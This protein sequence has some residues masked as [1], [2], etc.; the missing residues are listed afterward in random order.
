MCVGGGGVEWVRAGGLRG[1][2]VVTCIAT[3]SH[4]DAF[5]VRV[6]RQLH[7]VTL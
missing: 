5:L 7:S 2:R 4:I 1:V 3:L 6:S